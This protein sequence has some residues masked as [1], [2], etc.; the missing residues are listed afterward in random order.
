MEDEIDSR[1]YKKI[2]I[3]K[4]ESWE[5]LK[6]KK[7]NKFYILRKIFKADKRKE[8]IDK[9]SEYFK[10]LSKIDSDYIIKYKNFFI[11]EEDCLNILMENPGDTSLKEFIKNTEG[12]LFKESVI[13]DILNQICLGLKEIHEKKIILGNLTPEN[14]YIDKDYNIKIGD[15]SSNSVNNKYYISA[16][17]KE[18]GK[19]DY[20]LD[21]L[22][23]IIYELF[24]LNVYFLYKEDKKEIE[25]DP[26]YNQKWK[27]L[28][29]ILLKKSYKNIPDIETIYYDNYPLRNEI[30]LGIKINKED[31][32]KKIYFLDNTSNHDN[33]KE[34]NE[35]N[36]E[37]FIT[38]K[39]YN[40]GKYFIPQMDVIYFIKIIFNFFI[41]DCS[42]MFKSCNNIKEIY[43][44]SFNTKN[45]TNMSNMF[46]NCQNL[47]KIIDLSS[48]NTKN[49]TNMSLMFYNCRKLE[50][51]DLS[52][53]ITKNVKSMDYMFGSC[54]NLKSI[55]LSSF[56][57]SN[58]YDMSYMF[59]DC[60]KLKS[61]DLSSFN[62][63]Y[64]ELI[65]FGI[66]TH[67][68]QLTEIN[69]NEDFKNKMIKDNPYYKNSK[70]N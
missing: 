9:Y 1:G 15:F 47:E 63:N 56:D 18:G 11:D 61:I 22:G 37:I 58:V 41:K 19:N 44:T 27:E 23:C 35:L 51:I 36:T 46:N 62:N 40:F 66:F 30:Q 25:I 29:N 14:I 60:P 2:S 50:N 24:T 10:I 4:G 54:C 33:L 53:F 8:E 59:C 55:N 6:L 7:D 64:N 16:E 52:S 31:I 5:K 45:I 38:K 43:L 65:M 26:I 69:F 68:E 3:E 49:V 48:I 57:F 34:I 42:Y 28:I 17:I 32:G 70:F 67:C 21:S 13:K 20:R 12:K 39:K